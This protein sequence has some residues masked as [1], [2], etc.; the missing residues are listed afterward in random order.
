MKREKPN[1][2]RYLITGVITLFIFL[3]GIFFGSFVDSLKY[4]Y[5]EKVIEKQNLDLQLSLIHI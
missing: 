4:N 2:T 1:K 5:V 3:L